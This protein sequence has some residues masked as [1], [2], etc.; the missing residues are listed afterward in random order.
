MD[1]LAND[2]AKLS[3]NGIKFIIVSSGAVGLGM[4]K[5]G[6]SER[7]K[8]LSLLR[9]CASIGQCQLMNAWNQ[10]LENSGLLASQVLLTRED[11]ENKKGLK[12]FKKPW[13]LYLRI[14]LFQ[15]LMKMTQFVMKKSN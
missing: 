3:Q 12:K 11:F 6:L 5:L 7:P 14:M 4:G 2:I 9:A 8:D 15:L 1:N 13:N 10:S